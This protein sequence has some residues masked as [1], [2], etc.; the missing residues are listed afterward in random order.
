MTEVNAGKPS[1]EPKAENRLW[2]EFDAFIKTWRGELIQVEHS[3][4]HADADNPPE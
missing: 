4:L 2:E 1:T 3:P